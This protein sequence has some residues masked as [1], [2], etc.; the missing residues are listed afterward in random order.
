MSARDQLLGEYAELETELANVNQILS[1]QQDKIGKL[2]EKWDLL[3]DFYGMD[4]GLNHERKLNGC[5]CY[6]CNIESALQKL[7][8]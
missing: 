1:D 4:D 2:R 3:W 7:E 8:E 6:W 5:K